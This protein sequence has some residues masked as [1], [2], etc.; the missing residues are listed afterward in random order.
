MTLIT[1]SWLI[2]RR[3]IL[4]RPRSE[5]RTRSPISNCSTGS[6]SFVINLHPRPAEGSTTS[7]RWTRR[8]R[9]RYFQ[10]YEQHPQQ[11]VDLWAAPDVGDKQRRAADER[12]KKTHKSGVRKECE[13]WNVNMEGFGGPAQ[14]SRT[15]SKAPASGY[16]L[17]TVKCRRC[18]NCASVNPQE[19]SLRR[20]GNTELGGVE[21]TRAFRSASSKRITGR[22]CA[23]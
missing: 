19:I 13:L 17:L 8:W 23:W 7:T 3:A 14:P 4:E 5:S 20:S 9:R 21:R 11:M 10:P 22:M 1:R 6:S 12:I 16:M 2:S 18:G 15:I